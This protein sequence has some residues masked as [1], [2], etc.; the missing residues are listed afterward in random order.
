MIFDKIKN[1]M[2]KITDFFERLFLEIG[3]EGMVNLSRYF[4]IA[5]KISSEMK[6]ESERDVKIKENC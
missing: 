1:I 5:K 6:K 3:E 4:S 2:D